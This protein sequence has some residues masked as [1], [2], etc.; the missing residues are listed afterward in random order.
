MIVQKLRKPAKDIYECAMRY[1]SIIGAINDI[2]M[3]ERELQL[4]AFAA[5]KGNIS[6]SKKEFCERYGSSPA[7][8]NNMISK[9]KRLGFFVKDGNKVKVNSVIS[10]DFTKD[11]QLEIK[12]STDG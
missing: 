9:L 12:L 4:V 3:T 5:V 7:T 6:Y 11:V 1:Y 10:L 8:V 2:Q